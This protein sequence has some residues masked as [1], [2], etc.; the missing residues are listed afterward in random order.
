M[1]D[2]EWDITKAKTNLRKHRVAFSEATTVLR[3]R[4]KSKDEKADELRP[5][6]DLAAL[7]KEGVRGKYAKRYEQG[8]NLVLLSP[9]VARDF[10]NDEAV[11][12]ALRLVIQLRKIPGGVKRR[13]AGA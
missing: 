4:M 11:N 12:E 9:D 5:E 2:F 13:T 3:N 8:T 10:P 7:L 6:Y 1:I